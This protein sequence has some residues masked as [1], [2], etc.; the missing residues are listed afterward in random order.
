MECDAGAYSRSARVFRTPKD[1]FMAPDGSQYSISWID[2]D[3]YNPWSQMYLVLKY[4]SIWHFWYTN[5][6][7]ATQLTSMS[8]L[9]FLRLQTLRIRNGD[10][11]TYDQRCSILK[12]KPWK[13]SCSLNK[14]TFTFAGSWTLKYSI[15]VLRIELQ[16]YPVYRDSS[17]WW[18]FLEPASAQVIS[19]VIAS[20]LTHKIHFIGSLIWYLILV[21]PPR[22]WHIWNCCL[23]GVETRLSRQYYPWGNC[24]SS[25]SF[26]L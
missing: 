10:Q 17:A 25:V 22:L 6:T 11:L 3:A 21:L 23:D 5:M 20:S 19:V 9:I 4:D 15:Q 7:L 12:Q 1:V 24:L 13:T 8:L 18:F 26:L 16:I 2:P 14:D